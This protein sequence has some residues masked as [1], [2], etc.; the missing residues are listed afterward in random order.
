MDSPSGPVIVFGV[1]GKVAG[2]AGQVAAAAD[3]FAFLLAEGSV[4]AGEGGH[5]A[6]AAVEVFVEGFQLAGV[7]QVHGIGD[8]RFQDLVLAG[9][10]V[11]GEAGQLNRHGMGCS[12]HRAKLKL[13]AM[14]KKTFY[15]HPAKKGST[16]FYNG[17]F[18]HRLIT[19]LH[20]NKKVRKFGSCAQ[21]YEA[22]N[23]NTIYLTT[24][25]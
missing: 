19:S 9:G 2:R 6:V 10:P 12:A 8:P 13:L 20:W 17:L 18:Q 15:P 1:G 14:R 24:Q 16:G 3:A 21:P 5:F 7:L 22:T 25:L 11:V 23:C 4:P